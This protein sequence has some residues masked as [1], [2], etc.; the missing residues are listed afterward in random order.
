MPSS[1]SNGF[2]SG[3]SAALL[4]PFLMVLGFMIWDDDWT[5]KN[6]SAFSLNMFKCNLAALGFLIV[7]LA[8]EIIE[9]DEE[10]PLPIPRGGNSLSE[11]MGIVGMNI[12]P[13]QNANVKFLYISSII[14]ILIGDWTWLEGLKYLGARKVIIMD[15]LKPFLAAF[16]GWVFFDEKFNN[17]WTALIGLTLTVLGVALV[18]FEVGHDKEQ[19][20]RHGD[21]GVVDT[22]Q[23]RNGDEI[24]ATTIGKDGEGKGVSQALNYG[25]F[26]SIS[27]VAL[28]TLGAC[29]TKKFG[30]EMTTWEI[31]F[32]RFGF[33]GVCMLIVAILLQI[34]DRVLQ[35]PKGSKR[36]SS[37][38]RLS[39]SAKHYNAIPTTTTTTTTV[40]SLDTSSIYS[41]SHRE[42]RWYAMPNLSRA[43]WVRVTLGVAFVSFMNP[44]LVNYAMFQIPFALLLTL[45]SIGPLYTLPLTLVMHKQCPSLRAS[46]G[47]A[48]AVIGIILLSL[49]GRTY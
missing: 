21:G 1:P 45:E 28:H 39:P 22:V 43:S 11:I 16:T 20:F 26:M 34:R 27:N 47:A 24:H 42:A 31:N 29:L 33:S 19:E 38:F 10:Q 32:V 40:V 23:N 48:F 4:G 13:F 5:K 2:V 30:V 35:D 17:P 44:A 37:R 46:L 12:S 36:Q 6:G 3:V 25:I 49:N 14:G 9:K 8:S 41:P 18:G 15:S 7:I